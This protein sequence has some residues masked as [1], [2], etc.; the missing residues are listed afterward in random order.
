MT[1]ADYYEVL[2]LQKNASKDQIKQAYKTLAKKYHPD[3][4]KEKNAEEKFKELSEAYAVLSDDQKRAAYDQFGHDAF[5]QRYSREDI[6]R[7]FDFDIFRDIFSNSNHSGFES[8]FETFFGRGQR[9]ERDGGDHLRYDIAITLEEAHH[10]VEKT[11]SIQRN[12]ACQTCEGHGSKDGKQTTC[13]SC[14]GTGQMRRTSRSVFGIFQQITTCRDCSGEGVVIKNPCRDCM[15]SGVELHRR[16]IRVKIPAGVDNGSQIRLR[17][18]GGV[19][20]GNRKGDLFIVV[21]LMPHKQFE[22]EGYN[23]YTEKKIS[24]AKA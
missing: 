16:D 2:G 24:F 13:Q 17:G 10:G 18:E 12:E 11:I 9:Q 8:I 1:K 15:G 3:I 21:H 5:D 22:R 4:S 20:R 19:T 23:L 14:E 6:F 7:D